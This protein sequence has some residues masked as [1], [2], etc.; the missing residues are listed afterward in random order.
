MSC[1]PAEHTW[2][3]PALEEVSLFA[4]WYNEKVCSLS[5]LFSLLSSLSRSLSLSLSLSAS[6]F[7]LAQR[8]L[9]HGAAQRTKGW[10]RPRPWLLS[11]G[12]D[13]LRALLFPCEGQR[14]RAPLF[15]RVQTS[16][17]SLFSESSTSWIHGGEPLLSCGGGTSLSFAPQLS[18]AKVSLPHLSMDKRQVCSH[19]THT[20]SLHALPS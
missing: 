4:L 14:Q 11:R 18:S 8:T 9:K 6:L 16:A 5:S 15:G 20:N 19:R 12:L 3:P 7:S 17:D 13:P 2:P 10:S 1:P